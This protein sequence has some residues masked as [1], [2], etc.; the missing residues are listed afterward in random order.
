M[1]GEIFLKLDRDGTEV[2]E[3]PMREAVSAVGEVDLAAWRGMVISLTVAAIG[4]VGM[5]TVLVFRWRSRRRV[6]V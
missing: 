3:L 5:A 4:A 2:R 6:A 1:N